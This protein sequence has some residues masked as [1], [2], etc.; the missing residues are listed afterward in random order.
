MFQYFKSGYKEDGDFFFARSHMENKRGT[1]YKLFWGRFQ[2][3]MEN[4]SQ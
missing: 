1:E 2:L 4:L 3:D